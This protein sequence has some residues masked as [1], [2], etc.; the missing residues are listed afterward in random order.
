MKLDKNKKIALGI[1]VFALLFIAYKKGVFG[2][3]KT[4][5]TPETPSTPSLPIVEVSSGSETPQVSVVNIPAQ[6][7]GETA[8]VNRLPEGAFQTFN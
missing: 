5:N 8:V 6:F 7:G 3:V 1:G 4:S 2:G